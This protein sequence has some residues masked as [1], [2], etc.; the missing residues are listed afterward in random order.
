VTPMPLLHNHEDFYHLEKNLTVKPLI[1]N[2]LKTS[3]RV[4]SRKS[5]E[6]MF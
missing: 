5:P 6:L 4:V 3:R 2:G 1:F